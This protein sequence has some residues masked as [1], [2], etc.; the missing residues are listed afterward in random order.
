LER[1]GVETIVTEYEELVIDEGAV[2]FH[3]KSFGMIHVQKN[4]I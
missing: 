3:H 2:V 1:S 4:L